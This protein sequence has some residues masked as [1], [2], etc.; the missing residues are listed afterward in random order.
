MGSLDRKYQRLQMKK[1]YKPII[2]KYDGQGKP[3][4]MKKKDYKRI[5]KG[6]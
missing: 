3:V 1:E 6:K 4:Y 2:L 5:R